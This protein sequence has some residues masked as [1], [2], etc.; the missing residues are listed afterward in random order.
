VKHFSFNIRRKLS[1]DS[2][3]E[4]GRTGVYA[5]NPESAKALVQA[6]VGDEWDVGHPRRMSADELRELSLKP[7]EVRDITT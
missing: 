3:P 5:K 2:S 7:G 6:A 1:A 4:C